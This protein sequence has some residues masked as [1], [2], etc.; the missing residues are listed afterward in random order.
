MRSHSMLSEG[1]VSPPA[2]S[3]MVCANGLIGSLNERSCGPFRKAR[4]SLA[5]ASGCFC[6]SSTMIELGTAALSLRPWKD[7]CTGRTPMKPPTLPSA[8]RRARAAPDPAR[9]ARRRVRAGPA[10]GPAAPAAGHC[11]TSSGRGLRRPGY[12]RR[13][14]DGSSLMLCR[15]LRLRAVL[16][17]LLGVL[18]D[19][20]G[21]AAENRAN[22]DEQ[23]PKK[24][25]LLDHA[26]R[27][28]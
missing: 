5:P 17:V 4:M 16:G 10:A 26:L 13:G 12:P 20:C 14:R 7:M 21:R 22:L 11:G 19:G 3:H 2:F 15:R 18:A 1:A 28:G 24:R 27:H 23:A 8:S 25:R 6:G 9:D